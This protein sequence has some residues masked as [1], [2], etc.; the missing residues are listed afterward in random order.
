VEHIFLFCP[1]ARSI[2]DAVKTKVHLTLSLKSFSNMKLWV[3]AFL[4]RASAIQATTFAV[5]CWQIWEAR[6]DAR[7]GRVCLQPARLTSNILVYVDSIV[8]FCYKSSP[9]KRCVSPSVPTWSPPPVGT[10]C[11]NVDAAVFKAKNLDG[12]GAVI[13]DHLGSVLL[14]GHGTVRGGASPEIAEAF[15][16]RQALKIAREGGFQKIVMAS[17]CQSLVR[18]VQAT[19]LDR[20]PV[21]SLVADIRKLASVFS[22][23]TFTY[24]NRVFNVG[25]HNLARAKEP[26]VCKLYLAEI[27]DF[28]RD[29]LAFDIQ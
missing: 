10:V 21:G 19:A 1:F 20:S 23:C 15:A 5:T 4:E 3:F 6:N 11:V 29:G 22:G 9:P 24:V 8:K 7:N 27:P 17:D 28:V 12:W 26:S 16:M 18:K 2:W 14:A 13:R 25:A